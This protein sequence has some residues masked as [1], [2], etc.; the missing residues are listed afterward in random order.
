MIPLAHFRLL[1]F[2]VTLF[3]GITAQA[4]GKTL[5]I[6]GDS[7]SAG[8]GIEQRQGWVQLLQ[9]T[10]DDKGQHHVINASVSGETSGGG[11][12]RLPSLLSTHKPDIVVVEL[13]GNDGLRGHPIKLLT[14][15]L[16]DI[17]ALCQK[18]GADVL[19]LGMRIPP[20][21]GSRYTD[22]FTAIYSAVATKYNLTLVPF[23]LDQVATKSEWMQ[24]DGIHPKAAAQPQLL[25]NVLLHLQPLL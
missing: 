11:L 13:G 24:A 6:L 18:L 22:R 2:M 16:S 10:L 20:N 3:F 5:L 1:A 4:M 19:L 12:A 8:Y 9:E 23:F 25:E 17:A 14:K 7:L 15:N 21:Y